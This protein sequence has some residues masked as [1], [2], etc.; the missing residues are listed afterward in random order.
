[1]SSLFSLVL[2]GILVY[3]GFK[4]WE[5]TKFRTEEKQRR[6]GELKSMYYE[7]VEY[8][9]DGLSNFFSVSF[10]PYQETYLQ[11]NRCV[12]Q[13]LDINTRL[14]K[15]SNNDDFSLLIEKYSELALNFA[16]LGEKVKR[17][18]YTCMMD[19][20]HYGKIQESYLNS[21]KSLTRSMVAQIISNCEERILEKNYAAIVAIDTDV[22]LRCV[23]FCA[24]SK[25][26]SVE[27][28]KRAVFIF[29]CLVEK[30]H[31]D[32]TVAELYAMKQMGGED[33]L[34]E[35]VR[36]II[37][38]PY[39]YQ[40]M[41][42]IASSLMWLNAYYTENIVL[43]Y[44]LKE[45]MQMDAKT[46]E[47][48]HSLSNGGGNAPSSFDV[49]S[50]E[51]ELYFDVS[52]LAWKDGE[53]FGLFENLA[54]QEKKLL[55]SLAVRNED[56]NLHIT[57]EI[58]IPT[59]NVI[60]E[61]INTVFYEE[62]GG[63][64][65][66]KIRNCIALSGNDHEQM[67]GILIESNECKHMGILV[68][69]ARIGKRLNIR[70]YTLFLPDNDSLIEQRQKVISLYKQLSHSMT[71]WESSMKETVLLA[72]QQLLN[73]G[74]QEVIDFGWTDKKDVTPIF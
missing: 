11:L 58:E 68:H 27:L 59:V 45:G 25:P 12:E 20:V 18:P 33:I 13:M 39:S 30:P 19:P 36:H 55:Y 41:T 42:I 67:E 49:S 2:I 52:S 10:T 53:Y 9:D 48:L 7:Q 17:L 32:I 28:F 56:K 62:Y 65:T 38:T 15:E 22:I 63:V 70:F 6:I 16:G 4:I 64:V 74:V 57:K 73:C 71:V 43:Q 72:L 54:F 66:A 35:R 51:T 5:V 37:K 29:N 26:Y 46:Q 50:S 60:L 3:G 21:L 47:R 1:M 24:V 8:F 14:K 61:K 31:V 69:V 40:Q 44:M 34:Q 23:W